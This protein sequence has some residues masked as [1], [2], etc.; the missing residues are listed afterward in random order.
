MTQ[1]RCGAG[2]C[3]GKSDASL[4]ARLRS[5]GPDTELAG[6]HGET[7]PGDC[8][9][10][11][12]RPPG[13]S[14]G[15]PAERMFASSTDRLDHSADRERTVGSNRRAHR[16]QTGRSPGVSACG[17]RRWTI[18]RRCAT[19][20]PLSRVPVIRPEGPGCADSG[21][22]PSSAPS[23]ETIYRSLIR[24][25]TAGGQPSPGQ[26]RFLRVQRTVDMQEIRVCGLQAPRAR[27]EEH[28]PAA[29]SFDSSVDFIQ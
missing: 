28:E 21:P 14:R 27:S 11:G 10:S 25:A 13:S 9:D 12:G 22:S 8:V 3:V 24:P 15:G 19:T 29:A 7:A 26:F 16:S 2:R 20:N 6:R 5:G 17:T 4:S 18:T 23:A 1:R